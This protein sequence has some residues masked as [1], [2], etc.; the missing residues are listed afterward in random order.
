MWLKKQIKNYRFEIFIILIINFLFY[1]TN[2]RRDWSINVDQEFTLAYNALLLNSGLRQEY[3]DHP[4][5][6]TILFL[7]YLMKFFNL[8]GHLTVENIYQLNNS[9]SM[10]KSFGEM[11]IVEK[12]LAM[13]S[14]IVLVLTF[15]QIL[16]KI[17]TPFLACI[18]CLTYFFSTGVIEHFINPRTELITFIIFIY[19][20]I[21]F[22][23]LLKNNKN[24]IYSNFL[25]FLLF[26]FFCQRLLFINKTDSFFLGITELSLIVSTLLAFGFIYLFTFRNNLIVSFG[27]SSIF[28]YNLA[29]LNKVQIIYYAPFYFSLLALF[30]YINHCTTKIKP[31]FSISD[32]NKFGIFVFLIVSFFFITIV[33]QGLFIFYFSYF[34]PF[35]LFLFIY[36]KFTNHSISFSLAFFN[37]SF[38]VAFIFIFI[39]TLTLMGHSYDYFKYFLDPLLMLKWAN[40]QIVGIFDF[41]FNIFFFNIILEPFN[42]ILN[43]SGSMKI[44]LIFNLF[45]LFINYNRLNFINL[46]F[47]FYC[48]IIF[49]FIILISLIRYSG[50]NYLL[51]SEVIL[52]I[53]FVYLLKYTKTYKIKLFIS[54]L[55]FFAIFISNSKSVFERLNVVHNNYA[56]ICSNDYFEV[57][58]RLID[59][60]KFKDE[61]SK[62]IPSQAVHSQR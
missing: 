26:L 35:S 10:F 43:S 42:F 3:Y 2:Y 30:S 51:F 53:I 19:S 6:I 59:L 7:S 18:L 44:I 21:F 17:F 46:T 8:I 49:Y 11:V 5:L 33:P 61:C 62:A 28:L 45:I 31:L 40:K 12:H 27:F 15:L 55:L 52:F 16:K 32:L 9:G 60:V 47:I 20:A 22:Y 25:I 36:W 56:V 48:F 1:L 23:S 38:L 24:L 41:S 50:N 37:A 39:F 4:G 14:C 57:W 29:I 13:Y 34:F 54:F 58:H